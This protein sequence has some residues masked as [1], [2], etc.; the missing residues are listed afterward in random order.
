MTQGVDTVVGHDRETMNVT[1][2]DR[3]LYDETLAAQVLRVPPSTLHWWLEGGERRGRRYEPVLRAASTGSKT[4]TWGEFV[5]A[6]YLREYRRTHLVPLLRLRA[7]ISTLRQELGVPYPLATA[8]PWVGPGRR[9]FLEAQ[10]VAELE[11]DL[12]ACVEPASGATPLLLPGAQ[13]FY[14]RVE[15]P[16]DADGVALRVWPL[17]RKTPL[18]IDPHV[19]FGQPTVR[20]I[21]TAA[22]TGQV[23]AGDSIEAVADDFNLS[24]DDVVVALSYENSEDVAA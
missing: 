12:W 3:E 24:L 16:E 11:P 15:F 19:R 17:G 21:P 20:G 8:R 9:L 22:L 7:F 23:R 10:R 5:E 14:E 4:V 13:A 2:L 6:R 18:V 1:V